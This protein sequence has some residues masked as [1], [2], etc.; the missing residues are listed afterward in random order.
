MW[1]IAQRNETT[2]TRLIQLNPQVKIPEL[3][4]VGQ[5]V[6][7]PDQL[8]AADLDLFARL[9][10]AESEGQPY[11]G[12]VAVAAVVL[13]RVV[14]PDFPNTLRGVIYERYGAIPAFSPVDNGQINQAAVDSAKQAVQDALKGVDPS[15]GALFF[16]NPDYTSSKNW[17]RSLAVT[18]R[19]ADHVFCK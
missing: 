9:V 2:V 17:I 8:S 10:S 18:V 14:S 4:Y 6:N 11:Q 13:N 7:V 1:K 16:Y 19:I 3:I 5:K 12:Q 15:K